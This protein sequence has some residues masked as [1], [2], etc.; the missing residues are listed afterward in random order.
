[1]TISNDLIPVQPLSKPNPN[2]TCYEYIITESDIDRI[3]REN[4]IRQAK[5]DAICN[6]T[7]FV[8]LKEYDEPT[9]LFI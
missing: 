1:M 8:W 4:K 5:L 9:K 6:D 7:E 2:I 3:I